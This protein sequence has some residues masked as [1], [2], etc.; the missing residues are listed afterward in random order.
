MFNYE[1]YEKKVQM[2][3]YILLLLS[4]SWLVNFFSLF[5]YILHRR[6][7]IWCQCFSRKLS[8]VDSAIW[9]LR[10]LW[11]V[12][13]WLLL[14]AI[15]LYHRRFHSRKQIVQMTLHWVN[16]CLFE[17]HKFNQSLSKQLVM[18][19]LFC[20]NQTPAFRCET[21]IATIAEYFG[22]WIT[23]YCGLRIAVCCGFQIAVC[24]G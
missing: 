24:R 9:I 15:H 17:Q 19:Y 11:L 7:S 4:I 1:Y 23:V 13:A 10:C 22:L 6:R 21:C 3:C 18:F 8:F 14:F 16:I 5:N 20:N 2:L 12:S